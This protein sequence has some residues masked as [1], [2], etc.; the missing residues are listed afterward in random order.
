MILTSR[1]RRYFKLAASLAELS[2]FKKSKTGCVVVYKNKVISTGFN[3]EQTDPLQKKYNI[4]R[5]IPD[6]SPHK[7]HAEVDALKHIIELD[8]DWNHVSIYI[9]RKKN[10]QPYGLSR[11]CKSCIK[12][13][14]DLGIHDI[15][16]TTDDG[17]SYEYI[18]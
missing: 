6:S 13:I 4:E 5:N 16:Y 7:V 17:Y 18:K 2:T 1:D 3:K 15:Y 14:K 8:I 10:C 11:P 12:L 9:Y